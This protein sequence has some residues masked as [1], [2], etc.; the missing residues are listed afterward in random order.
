AVAVAPE[1]ERRDQCQS[2]CTRR[3]G[4]GELAR[5]HAAEGMADERDALEPERLEQLVIAEHQIPE[6]VEM[7]NVVRRLGRRSGMLR[8][9]DGG[10]VG[11]LVEQW[12]AGE[13]PRTVEE[14]ER[15]CAAP[16]LH[17]DADLGAPG[18]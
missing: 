1:P 17:A 16:G 13:T 9:V 4:G 15:R 18:R 6:V 10:G 2:V 12:I 8:R 3:I 7:V 5:E 11:E 14:D